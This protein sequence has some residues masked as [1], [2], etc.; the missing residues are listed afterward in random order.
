MLGCVR[1]AGAGSQTLGI[2]TA[3]SEGVG[4]RGAWAMGLR[5]LAI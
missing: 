4:F 3:I 1:L 5:Q 2:E